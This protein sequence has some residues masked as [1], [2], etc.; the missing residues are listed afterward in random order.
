MEIPLLKDLIIIFALASFV[1]FISHKMRIPSIAGLLVAGVI[2]GPNSFG[3]VKNI[4]EVETLA[5][6]GIILLLFTVGLEFSLNRL[7]HI[8][9]FFFLGGAL[10]VL[11]TVFIGFLVALF[12]KRPVGEALFLGFLLS[13]S[14]TAIVLKIFEEKGEIDSEQGKLCIAILIFQDIL[15]VP[16]IL[17]TPLLGAGSFTLNSLFFER[18]FFGSL[19]LVFVLLLAYRVI[20]KLLFYVAKAKSREL[21]LF[22]LLTICFAVAFFASSLGLT[23]A[24]GA[25]FAGL[26][27]SESDYRLEAL[28]NIM[29]F[30]DILLGLFFFSVGMLLDPHFF[31]DHLFLI[32]AIVVAV[33]FMKAA[34]VAITA[35]I[36][37]MPLRV[38]LLS[39][40]ALCQIGEF[41]FVLAKAGID[42]G[43]G[44]FFHTQL[45]LAVAMLSMA[46]TPSLIE[47]SQLLV[48][49]MAYLP[50]PLKLKSGLAISGTGKLLKNHIVIIGFGMT[51]KTI[52]EAAK[53]YQVPY[54]IVDLNAEIVKKAKLE[55]EPIHFGDA[56][57]EAVLKHLNVQSAKVV[58]IVINDP[59]AV[60]RIIT[61]IRKQ[62]QN[63][64]IIV[65]TKYSKEAEILKQLGASEVIVDESL[66][67]T[68]FFTKVLNQFSI[69][70][71]S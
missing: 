48:N 29:P 28:G 30:Q 51:G 37:K 23:L 34:V 53:E 46:L 55:S 43:L 49:L 26:I 6:I 14:S 64:Y 24:I 5:K 18:L 47:K 1:L 67:S 45:F 16:M 31:L 41:S 20:P 8:R 32:V 22:S 35:Y 38:M 62:S 40:L 9:R 4:N 15:A 50:L 68:I 42:F 63:C 36:L 56:T 59:R 65:R 61:L 54:E 13:M 58:A 44:S 3:I 66:A 52:A 12:L 2:A 7:L 21:F 71:I 19:L 33:L 39:G 17:V 27:I 57:H 60:M 10:Q 25:F 11:L 70:D 69:S